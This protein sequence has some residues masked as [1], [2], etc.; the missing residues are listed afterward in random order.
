MSSLSL[1]MKDI[2]RKKQQSFLFISTQSAIFA[3]GMIFHGL[4]NSIQNQMVEKQQNFLNCTV[5]HIFNDYLTY[6]LVFAVFAGIIVSI[7]LSALLTVA[8]MK[9]LAIL[10]A[11]GGTFKRIQ[12]VILTQ[13]FLINL[14]SGIVGWII[15]IFGVSGF[16]VFFNFT[17]LNTSSIINVFFALSYISIQAIGSYLGAGLVVYLLIRIK[18]REIIEGQFN[19]VP[20]GQRVWGIAMR[21]KVGFLLA[22]I[23]SKRSKVLSAVMIA[24]IFVLITLSTVGVLGSDIISNTTNTLID[25]GYGNNVYIITAPEITPIIQDLYD[26]YRRVTFDHPEFDQINPIPLNFIDELPTNCSYETRLLLEGEVDMITNVQVLE[27]E[28]GVLING[29]GNR[30]YKTYYWGVDS[31]FSLINY[32][33]VSDITQP[34]SDTVFLGDGLLEPRLLESTLTNIL[35]NFQEIKR[36]D[37]RGV[38]LDPFARGH[39]IYMNSNE[40]ASLK[41][42]DSNLKNLIFVLDP[43][44]SVYDLVQEFSL[45]IFPLNGFK[46]KYL[47]ITTSFWL[48]SAIASIPISI[49]TG[50]SLVAYS[51]LIANSILLKDLKIIRILGGSQKTITRVILW[52]NILSLR[53]APLAVLLGFAIAYSLLISD[54]VLPSVAAGIFLTLEFF[55]CGLVFYYYLKK[56][57]INLKLLQ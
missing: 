41:N 28:S 33:N 4:A 29:G 20:V 43:S 19:I 27:N 18:F 10:L 42:L 40:L 35:C 26:P 9:D 2:W 55:F 39:C 49:S 15:G 57:L 53:A 7:I 23:L 25:R 13:I 51:G 17:A 45:E 37:I 44:D 30:T 32:Y 34:G 11:L 3:S 14:L 16:I 48:S 1:A 24:G 36:F 5:V 6:M 8:R 52:V 50:L 54:P 47:A 31:N 38:I 21:R 12:R 56:F 46:E 22:Y